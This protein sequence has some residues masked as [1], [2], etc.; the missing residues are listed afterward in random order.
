MQRAHAM[1]FGVEQT[2]DGVRFAL[3][4]PTARDVRLVLDGSEREMPAEDGGWRRL[5]VRGA[6]AGS[7]YGF[8]IDGGLV[9]PDPASRF[10]PDDVHGLGLVVNPAM[11]RWSDESWSGR[12]WEETVLYELHVGT[13]TP[14]GTYAGLANRLE[15][16][17][18]LGVTAIELMP[19]N[20][21]A[22]KRNWGYDGVLP[23]A[24]DASYGTPDDLKRLV[25][26]AH[27][28]GLMVFLDVVYN[29]F[30]PAGNYLHAYAK[31]FFTERHQTPWGA[32]INVD[33]ESG[34]VVRDFFVHNALYW[35]EEFHIDGLRFDAV[36]AIQDDS[37]EHIVGE[38]ARRVRETFPDRYVHLV[39]EN[40]KNEARWLTRNE[41]HAPKLH[42]AQWNDDI[43]HCWH[44]LLTGES[45]AYYED[46]VEEPVAKLARCLAEGFAYQGEPFRHTGHQRGEPSGHLPPSAFVAFLQNHDQIG[47]RAMGER[48]SALAAPEKLVLARAGLILS[49]Q[50]P[51]LYMGEEW[52]A[53]SPFQFFVD[54]APD[55]ELSKAVRD[56]RRREFS[57]FPAFADP[58]APARIPDPTDEATF[59]R[60]R[61][62]WEEAT[63]S[64]HREVREEVHRLLRLRHEAVVPLTKT[65]YRGAQVGR[66]T[67]EALEVTWR[68]DGG[69]LKFSAN[70]GEAPVTA[71]AP[72]GARVLW[73][74]SR[75]Q[76]R[77]REAEL[78]SWTGIFHVDDRV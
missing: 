70:F 6:R 16:L 13:A 12:P 53:S 63:R 73:T 2:P 67:P 18:D 57:R 56:G 31:T 78:P 20:D 45:D 19:I 58:Q 32:G 72:E 62:D 60:S 14:E 64:P 71:E 77:G 47:N 41:A 8:R 33:G 1:P 46:F 75:L 21:F 5:I 40:E 51:M 42:T 59:L 15:D 22:G 11:Y 28:L 66:P 48:I 50:I 69:S 52:A 35:L 26:R 3:W 25:D 61:L 17:R 9:V 65:P 43:H 30:G 54:F 24:P 37:P 27:A 23:Y 49:P 68:F 38:I 36:H 39:L 44:V 34:E 55:E 74:N 76:P 29:H 10:Q 4:A 7:R